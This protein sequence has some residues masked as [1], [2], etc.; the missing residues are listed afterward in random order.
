MST[1]GQ[2][3]EPRQSTLHLWWKTKHFDFSTKP[4]PR[5][6]CTCTA[7]CQPPCPRNEGYVERRLYRRRCT[8]E[9]SRERASLPSPS[10]IF[11]S[12]QN[13]RIV[14][15]TLQDLAKNIS[16]CTA[17]SQAVC[18]RRHHIHAIKTL[19]FRAAPQTRLASIGESTYLL[20]RKSTAFR[21]SSTA[22]NHTTLSLARAIWHF[23]WQCSPE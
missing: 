2:V 20:S 4:Y 17:R 12:Y 15:H 23:Q 8:Q 16:A 18:T 19:R 6:C 1:S 21:T 9:R 5:F 3:A 14:S 10:P 13:R 22:K 11:L 7:H